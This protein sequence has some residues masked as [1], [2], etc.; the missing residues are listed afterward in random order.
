MNLISVLD[1]NDIVWL[2]NGNQYHFGKLNGDDYNP[3]LTHKVN[4]RMDIVE[5]YRVWPSL[6]S[7][8]IVLWTR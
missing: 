8:R 5:V 2:K 1:K 3:D 7:G 6:H 4:A